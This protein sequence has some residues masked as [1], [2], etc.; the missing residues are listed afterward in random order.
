MDANKNV[1]ALFEI[2]CFS[3]STNVS[4]ASSGSVAVSAAPNCATDTT[5]YT[6]GTSVTLTANP[7]TG[8]AFS[9]WVGDT[10]GATSPVT[11]SMTANKSIT[12]TFSACHVLATQVSPSG[13][14][15]V[16][17]VP[18]PNCQGGGTNMYDP[19]TSVQ[20][21]ASPVLDY[22]FMDWTGPVSSLTAN[23]TTVVMDAAHTV[24]ANF[25]ACITVTATASGGTDATARVES[26]PNCPGGGNRYAPNSTVNVSTTSTSIYDVFQ[27]WT[28][29]SGSLAS[30][31]SLYTTLSLGTTDAIVT[32]NFDTCK[33]LSAVSNPAGAGTVSKKS[34]A[35]LR[36]R[37][38]SAGRGRHL[39]R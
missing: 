21:T 30:P 25:Q 2:S 26:A 3:L 9:G 33:V 36:R 6:Y 18:A 23:P 29:A 20:L 24:T 14:G 22:A 8:Y 28:T 39:D 34:C 31:S 10:S 35:Q 16:D 1:T 4:P 5:R 37:P 17:A 32:A 19:G 27:Q 15:S 38:V 7:A 11:I 12:A 13:G